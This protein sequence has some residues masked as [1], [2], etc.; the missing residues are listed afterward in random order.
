MH[1]HVNDAILRT[2]QARGGRYVNYRINDN[3]SHFAGIAETANR[4]KMIQG[5]EIEPDH[6]LGSGKAQM[7]DKEYP[8]EE[9]TFPDQSTV[10]A[11][12]RKIQSMTSVTVKK[13]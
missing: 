6:P 12:I 10:T 5:V 7:L 2:D 8:L 3:D 9:L 13:G 1:F 11:W 4:L